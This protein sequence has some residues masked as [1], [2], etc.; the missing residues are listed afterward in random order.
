MYAYILGIILW[1][2]P[3]LSVLADVYH[4]LSFWRKNEY[5]LNRIVHQFWWDLDISHQYMTSILFR[6]T[7]LGL[8]TLFIVSPTSILPWVG[9]VL[10]Y[11]IWVYKGI[12]RL[13]YMVKYRKLFS[14][15][16]RSLLI[17]LLSIMI[18]L[19]I[20]VITT[21]A[22]ATSLY[23]NVVDVGYANINLTNLPVVFVYL[24][25]SV[26]LGLIYELTS[27]ILTLALVIVT[28]PIQWLISRFLLAKTYRILKKHK[29]LLVIVITG[30][31]GKTTL[32]R[33]LTE[34]IETEYKVVATPGEQT[35]INTLAHTIINFLEDDTEVLIVEMNGY[36]KGDIYSMTSVLKPQ[37][38]VITGID[39]THSGVFGSSESMLIAKSELIK[40]LGSNAT[41]VLNADNDNLVRLA[42]N[43]DVNEILFFGYNDPRDALYSNQSK[44]DFVGAG[45]VKLLDVGI[46]LTLK[47]SLQKVKLPLKTESQNMVTYIL[48]AV[49]VTKALGIN[50]EKTIDRLKSIKLRDH[51]LTS[52]D[53][54][55]GTAIYHYTGDVHYK[56][57][58]KALKEAGSTH[59]EEKIFVIGGIFELGVHK[60]EIY[61]QVYKSIPNASLIITNDRLLYSLLK[62]DNNRFELK[63]TSDTEKLIYL[64][65]QQLNPAVTMFVIG[66]LP[67]SV[68]ESLRSEI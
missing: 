65:R 62:K 29:D 48:A 11:G 17:I 42:N 27:P 41:L 33:L 55:N 5:K 30:S 67:H 16:W 22:L 49:S 53:G 15:D 9:V 66:N 57:F 2:F 19:V 37:I 1:I 63:Y 31:I 60:G 18:M 28:T 64:S 23:P 12:T 25:F 8:T 38:A 36:S 44:T 51:V 43:V 50:L 35:S 10:A 58:I 26:Q 40:N 14:T 68:L 61:K 56:A 47:T 39:E 34:L 32:K 4:H 45:D 6:L 13:E 54:D 21:L 3:L 24:V 20:P 46:Q 7:A 52:T 59:S